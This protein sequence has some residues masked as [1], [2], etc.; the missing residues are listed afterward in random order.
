MMKFK[1]KMSRH[2]IVFLVLLLLFSLPVTGC[3]SLAADRNS[4]GNSSVNDSSENS[5]S[6]NSSSADGNDSSSDNTALRTEEDFTDMFSDRDYEVGYDE[7]DY[8]EIALKGDSASCSSDAV[9]VSDG[10]VTI[11]DEGTYIISG[12]L[13][14]G[15]LIINA[16]EK[17]KLHLIFN[18]VTINSSTSA[19]LYILEADKVFIT[20]MDGTDN[21]LS[22]G[23]TFTA[24]D[25][26]NIDGCIFSKQD[27]TFNGSGSLSV[28]S[29]AGHGIVC[30]DDLVFISG[31][32][33]IDS[34][35]H[36]FDAND[37]I[38]VANASFTITSGKDGMHAENSDDDTLGFIYIESGT[39]DISAEGDGISA[40]SDM[41]IKD[42]SFT[43][44]SGGGYENAQ[45]SS[46]DSW[47]GFKG[48]GRGGAGGGM[49]GKSSGELPDDLPDGSGGSSDKPSGSMP[50]GSPGDSS[51]QDS[52]SESGIIDTTVLSNMTGS[53]NS[54]T[55]DTA[56]G[57]D[58]Q[59]E[60]TSIKGI[61]A[62]GNLIINGGTCSIN[63]ADDTIHSNASIT[64]NDGTFELASGDDGFHADDTLS[65]TGGTITITRSYEG[66]EGLHVNI[67][68]GTITLTANDDGLNAAGGSDQSGF[69]GFRQ[70]DT[71]G[72]KGMGMG[73]GGNPGGSSSSSDGTVVI[74]GG[75][76]KIT[77]S[78]D[79]IDS[80]GSL[81]I[82]GGN[83]TTCGPV[84][85]DTAVL[86]YDTTADISGGTFIGTGSS[87]MAQ[88]FSDS[89]QGVI[90][91]STGSQSAGTTI[92]LT[93]SSG[94]TILTHTPELP[95]EIAVISSPELTKGETFTVTVG[96]KSMETTA[97]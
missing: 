22:N 21:A 3:S 64:V 80:N 85:G 6:G 49:P 55:A 86:D 13:N 43:I 94:N 35:S 50:D 40:G 5:S 20:L 18:G 42:G 96:S 27:L 58:T 88:S 95:Y 68:G 46:S 33:T 62:A 63:S 14:D 78:G 91:V 89:E 79:G 2:Y 73:K 76:L 67:S 1:S 31:T 4:S 82:S 32:F 11:T 23:G 15:M 12:T 83:V 66:L 41:M 37:S 59:D 34:A 61:K 65:V 8:A 56:D 44:V 19:A 93:D 16:G 51:D 92:T 9:Q 71:F 36:G 38:R 25:D 81:T 39:F 84:S 57:S 72:G 87:Q 77:A 45:K 10:T 54:G 69:G 70:N 17:D 29:P 24:I 52:G 28:T 48:G 90:A 75:D 7:T 30:K 97:E 60:S 53:G 47:G 26:N 74:S